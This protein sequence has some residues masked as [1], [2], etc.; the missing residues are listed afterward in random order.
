[1]KRYN[2]QFLYLF[3]PIIYGMYISYIR[4]IRERIPREVI[5]FSEITLLIST[6]I[7][8]SCL[9]LRLYFLLKQSEILKTKPI[10]NKI[11][12]KIK[13]RF[14]LMAQIFNE[15]TT[16]LLRILNMT[17]SSYSERLLNIIRYLYLN[18]ESKQFTILVIGVDL[19]PK[20]IVLLT[21]MLDVFYFRQLNYFYK[22]VGLLLLPVIFSVIKRMVE[23]FY[24]DNIQDL[25]D[26]LSSEPIPGSEYHDFCFNPYK[27]VPDSVPPLEI[28]LLLH[29]YPIYE[30]PYHLGR[31]EEIKK[32]YHFNTVNILV[33]ILYLIGWSQILL[34]GL[35]VI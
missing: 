12:L 6:V 32:K 11:L 18:I 22:S 35:G 7:I 2:F 31:L 9:S 28:H 13:Y 24:I 20:I 4:L 5:I 15:S 26:G 19:V 1:M 3:L 16:G 10:T 14:L 29:F 27:D 17:F 21:F 34:I 8:I 33:C 25:I 30:I 23:Q